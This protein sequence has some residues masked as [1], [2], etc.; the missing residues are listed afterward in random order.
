MCQGCVDN[1]ELSQETYDAIEAFAK[2]W[3]N[4]QFGPAHIV[5]AD[6]NVGDDHIL[7]CIR[8]AEAALSKD[9][10][11][12]SEW[13]MGSYTACH[14]WDDH[15]PEELEATIEFLKLLLLVPEEGR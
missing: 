8:L 4:S 9:M 5:I 12:L 13:E 14:G 15:D 11:G 6:D 1:G 3:W 2:R 7:M 10:S